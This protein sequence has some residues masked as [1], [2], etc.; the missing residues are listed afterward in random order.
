MLLVYLFERWKKKKIYWASVACKTIIVYS[1]SRIRRKNQTKKIEI[2]VV[3]KPGATRISCFFVRIR[4]KTSSFVGS[5]SRIAERALSDKDLIN[6]AYCWVNDA[7]KFER[8]GIPSLFI[9]K[10]PWTPLCSS[11]RFN[12][13]S[14]SAYK[15]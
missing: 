13:S 15:N 1:F 4:K 14:T 3:Y 6:A 12:V 5:I 2:L 8:I 10:Y 7:S 9:I 11:I